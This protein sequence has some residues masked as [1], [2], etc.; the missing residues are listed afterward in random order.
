MMNALAA[1]LAPG[2]CLIGGDRSGCHRSDQ[3]KHE[4]STPTS[5][6]SDCA[7][8]ELRVPLIPAAHGTVTVTFEQHSKGHFVSIDPLGNLKVF[9]DARF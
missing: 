9:T 5:G 7:E 8:H 6:R 2:L 3:A 1:A 4:Q